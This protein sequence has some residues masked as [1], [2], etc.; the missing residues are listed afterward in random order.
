VRDLRRSGM[1]PGLV[2]GKAARLIGLLPETRELGA[3]DLARLF[4][5]TALTHH[6]AAENTE[7]QQEGL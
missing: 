6:R 7:N 4:E 3:R 2:L 5:R 1:T